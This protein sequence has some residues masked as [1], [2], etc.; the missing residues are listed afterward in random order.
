MSA[1]GHYFCPCQAFAVCR[2][3]FTLYAITGI[4]NLLHGLSLASSSMKSCSVLFLLLVA[5]VNGQTASYH[6]GNSLTF[7]AMAPKAAGLGFEAIA[8]QLGE[9]HDAAYHIDSAQ[10]LKTIWDEPFGV[11]GIDAIEA[12][13]NEYQNALTNFAWN[14]VTLQPYFSGGSTLGSDKARVQ[15][16]INLTRSNPDNSSTAFYIYQVWPKQSFGVF[17]DYWLLPS[18]NLDSTQTWPRR[19]YYKNLMDFLEN[20]YQGSGTVVRQIPTGE[21]LFDL[22]Q[23][24]AA[25]T[26]PGISTMSQLYRDDTHFNDLGKYIASTTIAAT[27]FKKNPLGLT[28]PVSNFD[29]NLFTPSLISALNETIWKVVSSDPSAGLADFNNDGA[30]NGVDLSIWQNNY[31]IN[32]LA[33][34]DGDGDTDGS[35]FLV[36]QRQATFSSNQASASDIV[37]EPTT[38]LLLMNIAGFSVFARKNARGKSE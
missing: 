12:P 14:A 31:S 32:D 38:C 6:I 17:T 5:T 19:E 7:D 1:A 36:W 21:V 3:V 2:C 11:G 35:D 23:Q 4:Y 8:S 26:L 13:Y 34:A 10:S 22:A 30:T 15:D 29:P 18:A 27:L 24:I 20:T 33:D 28:P 37:P 9:M 25:G 16:F